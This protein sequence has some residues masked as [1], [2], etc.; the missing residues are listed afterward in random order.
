MKNK[1]ALV[2]A[3]FN[4]DLTTQMEHAAKEAVKSCNLEVSKTIHVTGTFEIPFAVKK[5]LSQEDISA[6]VT[7]GVVIQGKTDHDIIITNAV[8]QKLLDI[9]LQL[10]KPIGSLHGFDACSIAGSAP[11]RFFVL[12]ETGN[13]YFIVLKRN[14]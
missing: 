6:A 7:L 9:S 1:I 2:V 4:K 13:S 12:I 14:V 5:A 8:A 3:D 11:K 10:E